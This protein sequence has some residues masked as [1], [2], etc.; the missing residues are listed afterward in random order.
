MQTIVSEMKS[1]LN[2]ISS[3]LGIAEEKTNKL[4]ETAIERSKT[5]HKEEI[6]FF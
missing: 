5:K 2:V 1:T 4:K 6:F 3:R